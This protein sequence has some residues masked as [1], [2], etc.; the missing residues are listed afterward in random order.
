MKKRP[1]KKRAKKSTKKDS[2]TAKRR[3]QMQVVAQSYFDGLA[4]KDLSAVPWAENATLRAPLN[5]NGGAEVPIE[6]KADILAFLN[7]LL[8]NLSKVEVVRHFVEGGWIC[9]QA[10]VGLATDPPKAL[11]LVDCFRIENGKIVEQENHYDP[12]PAL[13]PQT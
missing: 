6:G 3:A 13:P 9:T 1:G 5:P 10:N 12:R 7:P 4:K 11:R 2:A 8:P